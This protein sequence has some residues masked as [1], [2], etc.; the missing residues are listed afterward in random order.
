MMNGET[1]R[2]NKPII[3]YFL[4]NDKACPHLVQSKF[5]SMDIHQL[6]IVLL[7]SILQHAIFGFSETSS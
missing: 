6:P 1:K 2:E 7:T 5:D 4:H 3:S